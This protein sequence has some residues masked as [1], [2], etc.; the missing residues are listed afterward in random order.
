[1]FIVYFFGYDEIVVVMLMFCMKVDIDEWVKV[2]DVLKFIDG[3]MICVEE[4]YVDNFGIDCFD[5]MDVFCLLVDG[6][7][8]CVVGFDKCVVKG[9]CNEV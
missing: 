3:E 1:M 6:D 2:F 4:L 8:I 7:D 9:V 5:G